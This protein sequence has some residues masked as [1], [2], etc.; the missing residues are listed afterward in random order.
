MKRIGRRPAKCEPAAASCSPINTRASGFGDRPINTRVNGSPLEAFAS[1]YTGGQARRAKQ[2][3]AWHR[4]RHAGTSMHASDISTHDAYACTHTT[5][6]AGPRTAVQA[7]MHACSEVHAALPVPFRRAFEAAGCLTQSLH[8]FGRAPVP[9]PNQG[10]LSVPLTQRA[11]A[12]LLRTELPVGQKRGLR[13][14][15]SSLHPLS[16]RAASSPGC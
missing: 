8:A 2:A 4:D 6:L 15:A 3:G 14:F 1:R 16:S 11:L 10:S 13:G 9:P 12:G 5:D 7:A